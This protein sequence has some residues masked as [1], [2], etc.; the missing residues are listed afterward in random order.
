MANVSLEPFTLKKYVIEFYTNLVK[1]LETIMYNR[2]LYTSPGYNTLTNATRYHDQI[3]TIR[4]LF[5]SP[6]YEK[7]SN[8][9]VG[10]FVGKRSL[11]IKRR[12]RQATTIIVNFI[13][14]TFHF[15][16]DNSRRLKR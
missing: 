8:F 11:M 13:L 6:M 10:P 15:I 4:C 14:S 7:I 1:D 5:V 2:G 16:F 3:V 12:M 9:R